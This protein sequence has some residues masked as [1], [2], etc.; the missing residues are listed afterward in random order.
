[1]NIHS[2]VGMKTG[3]DKMIKSVYM[4]N[5]ATT[6]TKKEVVEAMLPYYTDIWGNASSKFYQTGMDAINALDKMRAEVAANIGAAK[7]NEIYFTG[8]GCEAD[9]WAIKGIAFAHEDKGNHI[10][11]SKIEHHAVLNTCA[12]LEKHGFKVTYIDVD[13]DG[14]VNPQDIEKAITEDTILIS[15]MTAN[16]EIG[17]IEPIKEIGEIARKHK[18]LFH[19]DAVQAIGHMP[20]NVQELGVDM[21]SVSA[22]KFHGPKGVG[23]LYIRNGVKIDNLIHGGGQERGKRAATENLAGI[24]GLSKALDIAVKNLDNNIKIMTEK[25]DRLIKGIR[26]NIPYC[27]LN[28]P[29]NEN[30]LCNNVNFSFRYVEGESILMLLNMYGIAASSGSACASGSLDPSHVLLAI[31]LPAEIAHGSVRLS[32]SEDTTNEEIDYVIEVLPKIIQRLRDMSPLYEKVLK[33]EVE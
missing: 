32:L 20:I 14:I 1:M 18:I 28:G 17:T 4:D 31:G 27:V 19:T 3:D 2:Y 26:D 24:A 9:N 21:M 25:R 7:P 16:N 8:S 30:R 5:N 10:I 6:A 22:H 11:T 29:E 13:S 15:I 33:G 12:Y 23:F